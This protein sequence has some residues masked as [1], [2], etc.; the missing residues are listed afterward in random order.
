LSVSNFSKEQELEQEQ[1]KNISVILA[2]RNE[3]DYICKCLDSLVEQDFP[4][5]NYEIIIVDGMST[6]KTREKIDAYRNR[7]PTVIRIF[8][9]PRKFQSSGRNIGIRNAKYKV[10]LIFDG[11]GI[12]EN[13][14]LNKVMESLG[15]APSYVAGLGGRH[16]S[17]DDE[18]LM[19]KVIADVQNSI[20]GGAGTSYR[21]IENKNKYVNTLSGFCAYKKEIIE[22]V[23]LYDE[24]FHVAEDAEINWRIKIAGYKLLSIY[25]AIIY[26]YRKYSSFKLFSRR[27]FR[28]GV[29]RMVLAKKYPSSMGIV[30]YMPIILVLSVISLPF[31]LLVSSQLAEIISISLFL[32]LIAI[33]LS[34][35]HI[36]FKKRS[37]KYMISAP[38]YIIQHFSIG[39][40]LL[41]GLIRKL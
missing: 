8:D 16:T 4:G 22:C 11:H 3:E 36:S 32:Y 14:Y 1:E 34:S 12:A 30:F 39:L 13:N 21:V 31:S 20:L 18:T 40:G 6:D 27:M 25:N 15:S 41:I 26:Y 29:W 2:I 33:G 7:F 35:L 23:G 9:N 19:G 24:R 28:Y 5:G 17:P 38:I 10:V 37:V